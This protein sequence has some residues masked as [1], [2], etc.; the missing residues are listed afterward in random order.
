MS[1]TNQQ[2]TSEVR[3]NGNVTALIN[4]IKLSALVL[5][6]SVLCIDVHAQN[7]YEYYQL[8]KEAK[9]SFDN[10][11][12]IESSL[13][14]KRAFDLKCN[15]Y[16]NMD[17]YRLAVSYCQIGKVDSAI[18]ALE[19]LSDHGFTY[20]SRLLND[21]IWKR[22]MDDHRWSNVVE[23]V[24]QNKNQEERDYNW[25]L[26]RNLRE[27]LASDQ[28]WRDSATNAYLLFGSGSLEYHSA[29][30]SLKRIDSINQDY[31]SKLLDSVGWPDKKTIDQKSRDAIFLV[32]QHADL[33]FQE[34]YIDSMEKA[35]QMGDALAKNLA[36]LQDR[37]ALRQGKSQIYG[38]QII[39][40][41]NTGEITVAPLI[42]PKN[43]NSRRYA[44]GLEPI[45]FYLSHWGIA[46]DP[47]K[48]L[49]DPGKN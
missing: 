1:Q 20:V 30:D 39:S 26:I 33:A 17:H 29:I 47:E 5:F 42:D 4:Q 45:E 27:L 6:F 18:I 44:V 49:E 19:Y 7:E 34:K 37:I 13:L 11:D 31:V 38:S 2:L 46:W 21:T 22:C 41:P 9:K 14:Y 15:H 3:K 36:L 35:V 24:K 10:E 43:V 28:T 25:T 23:K 48:Y 40:D 32:L 12:Y 16:K 8:S